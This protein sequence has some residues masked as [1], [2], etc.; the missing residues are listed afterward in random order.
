VILKDKQF[1]LHVDGSSSKIAAV[2][3]NKRFL[4]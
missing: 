3:E 2:I 1:M 4:K